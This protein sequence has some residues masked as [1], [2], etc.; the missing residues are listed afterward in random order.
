MTAKM[1]NKID[2]KNI[3]VPAMLPMRFKVV[4]P[5]DDSHKIAKKSAKQ[6]KDT[7]IEETVFTKLPLPLNNQLHTQ[8]EWLAAFELSMEYE[9]PNRSKQHNRPT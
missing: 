5:R 8:S 1:I 7:V 6:I 2:I 4:N 3:A 9:Q